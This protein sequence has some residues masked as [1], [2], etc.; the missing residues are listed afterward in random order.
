VAERRA[1]AGRLLLSELAPAPGLFVLDDGFSHLALARDLDLLVLPADDPYGCGRLLPGGRL[2]EPLAATARAQAILLTGAAA[3]P[4]AAREVGAALASFGFAGASFACVTRAAAPLPVGE[5]AAAPRATA[6]TPHLAPGARLL[7]VTGIARAQRVREAA[8]A[9]G[10]E[11]A[12]H[13]AFGDHHRYPPRSVRR[14]EEEARRAGATAVLTTS[15]DRPKLTGRLSLPLWEL[16]VEAEPE[17]ALW[18]WLDERLPPG[19]P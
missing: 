11:V 10:L 7:L 14:I 12:G 5:L 18:S 6:E 2:R 8:A 4:A 3:T 15:K 13:L 17:P 19:A 1:D 16:P 9:L